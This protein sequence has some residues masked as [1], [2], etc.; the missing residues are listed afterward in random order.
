L[1]AAVLDVGENRV[2]IDPTRVSD[3]ETAITRQDIR[4]LVGSGVIQALPVK[5]IS[6]GRVRVLSQKRKEGR[7][8]G[9]GSRK[10]GKYARLPKKKIWMITIRAIR[11]RLKSLRES[12]SI[13]DAT[14]HR[15]YKMSK[16]GVF[17]SLA[18]LHQY[19]ESAGLLRRK[20]K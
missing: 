3:V 10:G 12:K 16:G 18:D 11:E 15:L 6:R 17:K 2:W 9:M 5:G 14:Y 8:R 1:A 4:R 7:R 19:I 20:Q 13:T